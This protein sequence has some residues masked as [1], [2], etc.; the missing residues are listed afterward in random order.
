VL[1][2]CRQRHID[3]SLCRETNIR[4][5]LYCLGVKGV[6]ALLVRE[7]SEVKIIEGETSVVSYLE[8]AN[9]PVTTPEL[10]FGIQPS[11]V[12]TPGAECR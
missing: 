11:G 4:G 10:F 3:V 9:R 6:P 12:C 5:V 2:Y 7:G 1:E 8:K